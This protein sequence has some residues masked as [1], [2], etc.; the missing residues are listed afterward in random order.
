MTKALNSSYILF[1]ITA[2]FLS[3]LHFI[4]PEISTQVATNKWL[5][6]FLRSGFGLFLIAEFIFTR[7][8]EKTIKHAAIL[9]TVEF[10]S[11]SIEVLF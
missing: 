7:N 5:W 6:I 10:L 3:I 9:C 11:V 4:S 8:L 1:F 2:I